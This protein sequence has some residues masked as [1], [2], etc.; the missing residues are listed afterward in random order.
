MIVIKP[1]FMCAAFETDISVYT[2]VE[3]V[4]HLIERIRDEGYSNVKV[5]ES[6]MVWSLFY[7]DRTV[8]NVSEMLGFTGK[9]YEIVDLSVNPEPYDYGSN[10]LGSHFVGPTWR[11]ADYRISFAKNKTHFQSYYTGCMKN[12]YGC[13][14]MSDKL[15]HYHVGRR[16]FHTATVA[17]LEAFPVHFCFIDAYFSGDGLAGL[18]RDNTPNET[19][20]IICG[21]NCLAVDWVQGEKMKVGPL[22]NPVVRLGIERWG[23]PDIEQIGPPDKYKP[24]KNILPGISGIANVIEENYYISRFFC[25]ILAYRMHPRYKLVNTWTCSLTKPFRFCAK[26]IDFHTGLILL[27]LFPIMVFL[28]LL[29]AV[30]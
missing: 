8:K 16:E 5:V 13:L 9:G 22:K 3:L 17:I 26:M 19:S 30:K 1:N 15:K 12:V 18:I 24:W 6:Q 27:A 4:E 25:F 10:V 20:T 11:D 28:I 7:E 21:E 14:P 2:D 29:W 23:K